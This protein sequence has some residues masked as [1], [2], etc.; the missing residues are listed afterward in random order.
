MADYVP[1]EMYLALADEKKAYMEKSEFLE[2]KNKKLRAECKRL[3]VELENVENLFQ[4]EMELV[5]AQYKIHVDQNQFLKAELQKMRTSSIL[6][7][8]PSPSPTSPSP[9]SPPEVPEPSINA[10]SPIEGASEREFNESEVPDVGHNETIWCGPEPGSM[11]LLEDEPSYED[12]EAYIPVIAEVPATKLPSSVQQIE[13]SSAT[14][15]KKS[16]QSKSRM[17]G[18]TSSIPLKKTKPNVDETPT[19][20]ACRISPCE[21]TIFPSLDDHHEHLKTN[22]PGK[23][24]ICSRCPYASENQSRTKIHEKSHQKNEADYRKSQVGVHC[25]LCDITF[26]PSTKGTRG[27]HKGSFRKHLN[28]FH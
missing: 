19:V 24:F 4:E 11:N 22:H 20:F 28:Q 1:L 18:K 3:K 25:M 12:A 5:Y 7:M 6:P 13:Q 15:S 10:D 17:L 23:P 27:N 9:T 2:S 21:S 14:V 16:S 26:A 8:S